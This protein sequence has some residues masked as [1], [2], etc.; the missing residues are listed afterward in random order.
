MKLETNKIMK[1]GDKVV[2]I[3]T[4]APYIYKGKMY[5]VTSTYSCKCGV[6]HI[7]WGHKAEGNVC[8]CNDC[9]FRGKTILT[10]YCCDSRYFRKVEPHTFKN[11]V[12][13]ELAKTVIE[14][15]PET[16]VEKKEQLC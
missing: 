1:V 6:V 16:E 14:N 8:P 15:Q 10:E 5:E 13:K 11:A 9:G 4:V 2:C 12:T 3:K 7:T